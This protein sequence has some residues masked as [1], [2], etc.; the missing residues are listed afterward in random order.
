M[1]I[2]HPV[3]RRAG[4]AAGFT[5]L[6]LLV[7]TA[8]MVTV[9]G[10]T[11]VAMNNALRANET[12]VLVTSMNNTLRTGMDLM[13]R[14]LLQVGSG[15]PPGHV[16]LTPSGAGATPIRIPGPVGSNFTNVAGDTDISAVLP[17]PGLGPVVNG[18]PTDIITVLMADNNFNDIGLTDIT[19]TSVDVVTTVNIATGPDRVVPGQLMMVEKGSLSSLVQ[20]TAVNPSTRRITFAAGDSLNLNQPTAAA[21]SLAALDLAA[22]TNALTNTSITRVRM[23]TYYLDTQIARRPRLMRR[24][25][26]GHP[27]T[28]DNNLGTAVAVDV[29]NMQLTYDLADGVN[30]PSSVRFVAAD[31]TPA[32]PCNPNPCSVNQIRK[33][34]VVLT[35]RST[36]QFRPTAQFFRNSLTSQVSLRGMAF[37]DEYLPPQ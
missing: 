31:L 17:G 28:F 36:K 19:S 13:I 1:M 8:I 26:N 15:L 32:G 23:I 35:G 5:L 16:I 30:N 37:V 12:A 33:V 27:T 10:A 3:H 25:N 11:M 34:N 4:G 9:L 18:V 6:E 20:V 14:D 21:G 22:P 2:T 29:E 7:A 24:I